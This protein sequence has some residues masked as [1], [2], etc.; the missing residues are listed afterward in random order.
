MLRQQAELRPRAGASA[1]L[2]GT[3]KVPGEQ[4]SSRLDS[5]CQVAIVEYAVT[6][7]R[8]DPGCLFWS[9]V[10]KPLRNSFPFVFSFCLGR[11]MSSNHQGGGGGLGFCLRIAVFG[12]V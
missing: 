2:T 3:L 6:T 4:R 11:I 12:G 10:C 7:L 5:M 9:Q 1:R 8:A